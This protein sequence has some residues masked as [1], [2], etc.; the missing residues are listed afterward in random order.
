MLEVTPEEPKN[1]ARDSNRIASIEDRLIRIEEAHN[2][3]RSQI[4]RLNQAKA[5]VARL[6][7]QVDK[8]ASAVKEDQFIENKKVQ[9]HEMAKLNKR[10][11]DQDA[12]LQHLNK[13]FE[14]ISKQAHEETKFLKNQ[15]E[16]AIAKQKQ[17]EKEKMTFLRNSKTN[18]LK[19]FIMGLAISLILV[20]IAVFLLKTLLFS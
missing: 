14:F 20:V 10:I 6:K 13:K 17:L 15:V 3:T 16:L 4:S 18:L 2:I 11:A 9:A 1:T 19:G 5:E 8:S 12:E 7:E